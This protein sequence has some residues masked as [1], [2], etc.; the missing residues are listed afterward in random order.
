MAEKATEKSQE[1]FQKAA[2]AQNERFHTM[3]DEVAKLE[4]KGSEQLENSIDE[5][6][7]IWKSS[8]HYT[9]ELNE[10]MRSMMVESTRRTMD[11]MKFSA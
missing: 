7:R 8:L 10:H 11:W 1:Y 4:Q 6:A 2:E 5:M 9:M 3:L